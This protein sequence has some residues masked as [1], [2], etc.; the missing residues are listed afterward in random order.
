[1]PHLVQRTSSRASLRRLAHGL[2]SLLALG[3]TAC[4][5]DAE[6]EAGRFQCEA[7]STCTADCPPSG[8]CTVEVA[9]AATANVRCVGD[10]TV[11]CAAGSVC[12]VRCG[13]GTCDVTCDNAAR[14]SQ[15][16]IEGNCDLACTNPQ[17]TCTQTCGDLAER[18]ECSGCT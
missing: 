6:A 5:D 13:A 11:T 8:P 14:C 12:A 10:C 9:G 1:M 18:C 16:C 4:D 17:Q 2:L 7:A 15:T 3:A